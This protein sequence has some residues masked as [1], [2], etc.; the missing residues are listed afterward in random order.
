MIILH[1]EEDTWTKINIYTT[2]FLAL[3]W[4]LR[5]PGQLFDCH[6]DTLPSFSLPVF[7]WQTMFYALDKT[8]KHWR[9]HTSLAWL[10][11]LPSFH[12]VLWGCGV[13]GCGGHLTSTREKAETSQCWP[14]ALALSALIGLY[15]DFSLSVTWQLSCN[16]FNSTVFTEPC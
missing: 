14:N 7:S 2:W 15:I 5:Q 10:L 6:N 11:L 12:I 8:E 4:P 3:N 13:W 9:R 16:K 1:S